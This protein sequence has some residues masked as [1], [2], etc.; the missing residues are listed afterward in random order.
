MIGNNNE[1][2][3][4]GQ[5][6]AY[7]VVENGILGSA[8]FATGN[9]MLA[10]PQR[11]GGNFGPLSGKLVY[12]DHGS[13]NQSQSI[14]DNPPLPYDGRLLYRNDNGDFLDLVTGLRGG[15]ND[16]IFTGDRLVISHWGKSYSTGEF[17][18]PDGAIWELRWE[19]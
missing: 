15:R 18:Y 19:G 9:R 8:P 4:L 16:I 17:H 6:S 2:R 1:G 10:M 3:F 13:V 7:Y 14:Y 11:I 5:E 12:S